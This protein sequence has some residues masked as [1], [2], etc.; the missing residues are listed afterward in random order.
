M[1]RAD[2]ALRLV[3]RFMGLRETLVQNNSDLS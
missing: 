3:L 1:F 2:S